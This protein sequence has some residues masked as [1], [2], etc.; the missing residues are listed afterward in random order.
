M[1]QWQVL[2]IRHGSGM[3]SLEAAT[4]MEVLVVA[5]K[6]RTTV[7]SMSSSL[8]ELTHNDA[9]KEEVHFGKKVTPIRSM[10]A[11]E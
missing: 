5:A 2:L 4:P 7:L 10:R 9:C 3:C 8:I 6:T 11:I 1:A